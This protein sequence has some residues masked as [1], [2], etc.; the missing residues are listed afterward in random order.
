[1]KDTL[2]RYLR[3]FGMSA[4]VYEF[5]GTTSAHTGGLRSGVQ[6]GVWPGVWPDVRPDVPI[7]RSRGRESAKLKIGRSTVMMMM[8]VPEILREGPCLLELVTAEDHPECFRL[9]QP[10][11]ISLSGL[12]MSCMAPT[13]ATTHPPMCGGP[14]GDNARQI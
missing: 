8:V 1:M 11:F 12:T 5:L 14:R 13:W 10:C 4:Y 2:T 3:E 7:Q 6:P 9:K